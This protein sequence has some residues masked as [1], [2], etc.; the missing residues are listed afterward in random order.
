[1]HVESQH[2]MSR[3]GIAHRV[4][5]SLLSCGIVCQVATLWHCMSRC[6]IVHHATALRIMPWHCALPWNDAHHCKQ[7]TL[8]WNDVHCFGA[9]RII[10]GHCA[11]FWDNVHCSKAMCNAMAQ[12]TS[13]GGIT[14]LCAS[15]REVGLGCYTSKKGSCASKKGASHIVH[16]AG[17]H[18][19]PWH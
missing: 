4:Q 8:P 5:H 2:C 18:I 12:C 10:P 19:V 9:M 14:G 15:K 3:C 17:I 1:L 6:G 7:C 13:F 11:L 16:G